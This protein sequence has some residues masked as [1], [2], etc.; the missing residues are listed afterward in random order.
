MKLAKKLLLIIAVLI[1]LMTGAM[2]AWSAASES[3]A[4]PAVEPYLQSSDTVS[5]ENDKWLVFKPADMEP[6]VG[7]I[8]YPG[9]N[10]EASAYA[11]AL[12]RIAEAGTL[13]VDVPMP[14]NL[15]IFGFDRAS[16][17]IAAYPEIES[18]VIGG[19]SLGGA[20][21]ARFVDQNP[22]LV[23]GLALWA[24][25]PAES[26]SLADDDVAVI[27]ISGT[28]DGLANVRKIENS[29]PF[30]PANTRFVPIEGGNH[31]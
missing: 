21:A 7:F 24:A 4:E 9:A 5:V 17:V 3:Q 10:V 26:N 22:D 2:V 25:Y 28:L 15:A 13:V 30:L 18:W 16:K 14:L 19:H 6:T 29:V 23:D 8:F 31:A 20:M 12:S 11:P 27:S 1:V